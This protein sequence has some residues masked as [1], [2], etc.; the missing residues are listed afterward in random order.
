MCWDS[1]R[2]AIGEL[3]KTVL[4][5]HVAAILLSVQS[6]LSPANRQRA[7]RSSQVEQPDCDR[8]IVKRLAQDELVVGLANNG[9]LFAQ[10]VLINSDH[11]RVTED[12]EC[13]CVEL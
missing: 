8:S 4:P 6:E 12:V 7:R 5:P 3:T 1:G 2:K 13:E 10:R 11:F 9:G